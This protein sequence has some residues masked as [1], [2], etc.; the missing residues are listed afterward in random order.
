MLDCGYTLRT[1]EFRQERKLFRYCFGYPTFEQRTFRRNRNRI[2]R[3]FVFKSLYKY[4]FN[5]LVISREVF[6]YLIK[7]RLTFSPI[8]FLFLLLASCG[9]LEATAKQHF[10]STLFLFL[11]A[12]KPKSTGKYFLEI[13]TFNYHNKSDSTHSPQLSYSA[14]RTTLAR[15]GKAR[16]NICGRRAKDT[17]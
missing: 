6:N 13:G 1:H 9:Y 7:R 17:E 10:R 15:K 11:F 5:S 12:F 2:L 14:I 16:E 8:V 3:K 4:R